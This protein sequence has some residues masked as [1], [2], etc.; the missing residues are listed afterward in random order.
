M[1]LIIKKVKDFFYSKI[2][3]RKYYRY[4]T[5]NKCGA[6]CEN[7]YIRHQ[8]GIIKTKDEFRE[9]LEHDDYSFYH[10]ISVV[11]ADNFGLIFSCNKF[12]KEKR[13]CNDHKHRPSICRNYPSEEIF[14]F[15]AS[16]QDKCGFIFKPIISFEQVLTKLSK[17]HR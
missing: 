16:L 15:G 17:K 5:C 3:R 9:I 10:H 4:G 7:I 14:S 8:G 11:G 2:L 12:N 1:M 6:C 13:I